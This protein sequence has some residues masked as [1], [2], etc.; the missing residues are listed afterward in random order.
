MFKFKNFLNNENI[1]IIAK[2]EGMRV[3]EYQNDLS[4]TPM[5]ATTSYFASKMN[6]RKRQVLIE[7]DNDEYTISAGAM[8]WTVGKVEMETGIKGAGDF[9]GK[10]LKGAVTKESTVKPI[11]RGKGILVLEPT[12]R[13]ILL[14]DLSDWEGGMVLDDG[15]FLACSSNVNQSVVARSNLSSAV[16]GGEGLFNLKLEGTGVAAL[17]SLVPRDELVE[18]TLE[19]DVLKVDGNFAVAWSGT[20]D[21]TVEKSSKTLIGSGISGEGLVNVYRGT[22]KVLL[23]PVN[24]QAMSQT[25][26]SK[27]PDNGGGTVTNAAISGIMGMLK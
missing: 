26:G 10:A 25:Q 5:S 3:L 15:M 11:Y 27:A 9:I 2:K 12:Y 16:F 20:L 1:K 6:V 24:G 14:E 19:N 18:I 23:A 17:E 13:Y 21:F 4:V 22:G 7:L 8:Q